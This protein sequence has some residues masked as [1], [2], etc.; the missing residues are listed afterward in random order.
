[1]A[2]D[3]GKIVDG[4][5]LPDES[6]SSLGKANVN[7]SFGSPE[8]REEFFKQNILMDITEYPEIAEESQLHEQHIALDYNEYEDFSR[9]DAS[10]NIENASSENELVQADLEFNEQDKSEN[11]DFQ[12]AFDEYNA[13]IET[14]GSSSEKEN[15]IAAD[16]NQNDFSEN[17]ERSENS[18]LDLS[19][20]IDQEIEEALIY[21]D[22]SQ[23]NSAPVASDANASTDEDNAFSGRLIAKD[24]DADDGL[25]FS[26][27]E[28]TSE[29]SV[30]INS[31]G[32][33]TFNPGDDFQD[34]GVGESRDVT[35]SY[36][37][38]DESGAIDTAE[39]TISVLGSNDGPMGISLTGNTVDENSMGAVLGELSTSDLD[40][41]DNF[42]YTVSDSRFE[43]V[44]DG[45]GG[46][47]L[48]LKDGVSLNF[49]DTSSL[50]VTVTSTDSGGLSTSE[51]FTVVV[52]DIN[53]FLVS[54][55]E[56]SNAVSNEISEAA[57][58]GASVG[59][60][61]FA[62]DQDGTNSDVTY[63]LSNDAGGAFTIDADTGEVTVNDPS[64][65]NFENA[66]SMQI[67]VMATSEDGS[68]STQTFDIAINDAD[69]F[70]VSA[71]TDTDTATNEVSESATVGTSVGVTAFASD[72][73][74]TNSDV[75]YS[76]SSNPNN[77]FAID[78]DTG[79]VTVNDPSQLDFENAQSMQIEVTAT[80]ED[81][82][83]S[84]ETFNIAIN[85]ADE[86][87]VS[88]VT[89]TDTASNEVSESA[90]AGASVGVT[91]FASDDDGTN[92]DVTYSL[93][94]NPNNAFTIDSDTGEVTVANPAAL[95][96]ENAQSMQIEVTATSEDGSTSSQT[97]NIAINDADEFDVSAVTDSDT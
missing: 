19:Q 24:D 1:M 38:K 77:A 18:N 85:D 86:F 56:D 73:D 79:E 33:Y 3:K 55:I 84:S 5:I 65:L 17:Q 52:N 35:F 41:N 34:L 70:D 74:G 93:S 51:E 44:E 27:V 87:D 89:D 95:N 82:S 46:A 25:S 12:S 20:S 76:L 96:Y 97:F 69:E 40:A 31:D 23:L 4:F 81:G 57:T 94:S 21:T 37:V 63:S 45:A 67:E 91:A 59:V 62:E 26:L 80:S 50:N 83:T 10:L 64:Q 28:N 43:V 32:S 30:V 11:F 88:A 8:L 60:T 9:E 71:V 2:E 15:S 61:A 75:T 66:Q 78:S 36:Q 39:V 54:S 58:V 29:G 6:E 53:E 72:D 90:V 16:S 42:T 68:T 48:K 7:E 92:S 47:Q 22:S 14:V 13:N 49:E